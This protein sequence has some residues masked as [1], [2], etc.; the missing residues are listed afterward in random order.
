MI[1]E[2]ESLDRHTITRWIRAT[3]VGWLL[4]F[5]LVI[6]LAVVWDL[7]GGGA[8]FM[9]GIGMGAGVG[10]M[11]SRV[12]GQWIDTPRRW[13]WA[14]IV[15]M[16]SP[17]VLWDIGAAVGLES[18]FSLSRCVLVGGLLVGTLQTRLLPHRDRAVWWVLACILGWGMPAGA[19]ALIERGRIEGPSGSLLS[20]GA[21]LL[22]GV[23]L[24]AVTGPALM[25]LLRSSAT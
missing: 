25:R 5:V 13:L 2:T 15:G 3:S 24:G 9:V 7:I 19:I 10:Y 20:I 16:G 6:G 4:G 14:S 21:M 23:I 12:I 22:G 18:V 17:F 11:Q 8:Q 1:V